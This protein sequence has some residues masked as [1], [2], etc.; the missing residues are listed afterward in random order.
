[1]ETETVGKVVV[2][3]KIENQYDLERVE[4]GILEDALVRRVEVLD[5]RVDTGATYLSLPIRLINRLG[6][7]RLREGRAQTASGIASIGIYSPVKLTVEG[8]DC[9]VEVSEVATG[10]PTLIGYIPLELLDF[11]VDTKGQRLLGNPEHG[12]EFMFD[13]F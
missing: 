8:R 12:G 13:Q 1:M 9:I 4:D 2:A 3:A 6:L 10:C 11:V 5:A 7:R